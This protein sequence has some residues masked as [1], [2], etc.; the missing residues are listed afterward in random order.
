MQR[1]SHKIFYLILIILQCNREG[2]ERE[3]KKKKRKEKRQKERKKER[4]KKE[5]EREIGNSKKEKR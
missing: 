5:R 4:K 1:F 2:S 3:G